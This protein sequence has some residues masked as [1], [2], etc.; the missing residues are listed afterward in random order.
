MRRAGLNVCIL[1]TTM[2]PVLVRR[3]SSCLGA[4]GPFYSAK[5]KYSPLLLFGA[6]QPAKLSETRCLP[7]DVAASLALA[8]PDHPTACHIG[9]RAR[10]R[11]SELASLA[12][13]LLDNSTAQKSTHHCFFS[14]PDHPASSLKHAALP[15]ASLATFAKALQDHSTACHMGR[16][17]RIRC[18]EPGCPVRGR[19]N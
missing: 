5:T 1:V 15:V 4:A 12:L 8:L 6:R 7:I 16:H 17:A 9:R 13:A 10:M 18:S 14:G 2:F 11:C 19:R 3:A